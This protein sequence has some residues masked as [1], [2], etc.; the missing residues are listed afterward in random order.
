[1]G[2]EAESKEKQ[3][4]W[5]PML[6]V[7]IQSRLQ[8]IYHGNPM[9]EF[10]LSPSQELWIWPQRG[11]VSIVCYYIYYTCRLNIFTGFFTPSPYEQIFK[12]LCVLLKGVF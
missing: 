2:P 10:P 4:V 7:A 12:R 5:D 8:H 11:T 3:G 9:P 1:M 6:E